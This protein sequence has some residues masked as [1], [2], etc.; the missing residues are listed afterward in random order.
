[1]ETSGNF[2]WQTKDTP[3]LI[4]TRRNEMNTLLIFILIIQL[5]IL[6]KLHRMENKIDDEEQTIRDILKELIEQ[7]EPRL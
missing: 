7:I 4:F 6:W 5:I 2:G 3:P 1:M